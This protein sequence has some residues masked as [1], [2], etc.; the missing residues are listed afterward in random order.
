MRPRLKSF[1]ELRVSDPAVR[2]DATTSTYTFVDRKGKRTPLTLRYKFDRPLYAGAGAAMRNHARVH[3]AIPSLNYG[4][5]C[6]RVVFEFPLTEADLAWQRAMQDATAREQY[7]T[8]FAREAPHLLIEPGYHVPL[9]AFE[10]EA[11]R[12]LAE[13]VCEVED[14]PRGA[15]AADPRRYAVLSSGGK[16]SLLTYGLLRE[17]GE[18][19]SPVYVN[20]SGRHWHTALPAYRKHAREDPRTMRVWTTVDRLYV[21]ANRLLPCVRP[22]FQRV[23]ADVY[24]VQ[25]FTFNSYQ[26]AVAGLAMREG[27]GTVLMGNEFDEGPWPEHRGVRWW[28]AIYDQSQEFDAELN[29]YYARKGWPVR[30]TSLVRSL[31]SLLIEDLL[32]SRY[33]DLL[34]VQTSCHATHMEGTKVVP[35]GRCSKC[36]GVLLFLLAGGHDP[37]ALRYKAADVRALGAR[38]AAT[39]IKV[40]QAEAEHAMW[41]A[42][43][44]GWT[45]EGSANGFA[46]RAHPEVQ[47]VRFHP[48]MSRRDA[49]PKELAD[50]LYALYATRATGVLEKRGGAWAPASA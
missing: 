45:F 38:L 22:D 29:A 44:R 8:R 2:D 24:P 4:L 30:Q 6:D 35:C 37:K 16:E 26:V 41:L 20:E 3:H 21:G 1:R 31:S 23:A 40:D 14:E 12:D 25:L 13:I 32:A 11:V 34:K 18:D 43:K 28:H 9:D 33:P 5:F 50:R 46:P 27:I 49:M 48:E 42:Q 15:P 36:L 17:L 47:A 7:M 19:V 39:E 10:P